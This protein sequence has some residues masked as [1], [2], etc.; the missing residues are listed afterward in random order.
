[1]YLKRQKMLQETAKQYSDKK[2]LCE[3][4]LIKIETSS[5]NKDIVSLLQYVKAAHDELK[6]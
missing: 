2:Y 6:M 5:S 3:E 1:M 4:H